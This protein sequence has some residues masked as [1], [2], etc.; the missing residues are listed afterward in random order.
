M[1]N[2]RQRRKARSGTSSG[3]SKAAKR[4]IKKKLNRAAEIKGPEVLREAWDKKKTVRQNYID[5]GLIADTSLR[6]SGGTE[7]GGSGAGQE[8]VGASGSGKKLGKGMGRIVRDEEGNVIDIIEGG[9][10]DGQADEAT[11]WGKSMRGWEDDEQEEGG[12]AAPAPPKPKSKVVEHLESIPDPGPLPRHVSELEAHWLL[13]IVRK[14][15]DDVD[16]IFM[17]KGLNQLQKTKGEIRARIKR[18]GGI[19]K[20]REAIAFEDAKKG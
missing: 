5:L 15:G 6:P 3:P 16:A 12:T 17:D 10:E 19:D 7:P 14:H 20:I 13:S 9:E 8:S 2:P 4:E 11:P 18:A 1:A